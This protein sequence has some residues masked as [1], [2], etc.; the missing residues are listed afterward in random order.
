MK[1]KKDEIS[2]EFI[3]T[4]KEIGQFLVGNDDLFLTIIATLFIEPKEIPME[5]LAKRT[6]YSLASISNRIKLLSGQGFIKKIRKPNSKKLYLY[7]EKDIF[8]LV[9]ENFIKKEKYGISG[10]R[11]RLPLIIK[12]YKAKKLSVLQKEKL[13]IIESYYKDILLFD[14]L[15]GDLIKKLEKLGSKRKNV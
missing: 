7:M 14:E 13:K 8:K 5:E 11:E 9:K 2:E 6:G 12:K 3:S 15:I 4:Y 1:S 10:M